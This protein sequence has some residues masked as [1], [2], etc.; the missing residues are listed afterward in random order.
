MFRL[1]LKISQGIKQLT[2]FLSFLHKFWNG[3]N[4]SFFDFNKPK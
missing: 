2:V 4:I 3:D 1:L